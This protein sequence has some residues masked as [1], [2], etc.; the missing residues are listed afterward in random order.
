[1]LFAKQLNLAAFVL[2]PCA[3][4]LFAQTPKP[5]EGRIEVQISIVECTF[6]ADTD[7]LSP[8]WP[9]YEDIERLPPASRMLLD[10]VTA[11]GGP[12]ERIV[13]NH[14][15]NPAPAGKSSL[16]VFAPGE[17]GTKVEITPA[18]SSRIMHADISLQFRKTGG[19]QGDKTTTDIDFSTSFETWNDF[20]V[21]IHVS[22]VPGQPGRFICVIARMRM[23][24][25]GGTPDGNGKPGEGAVSSQK[26]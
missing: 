6:P 19:G 11:A 16:M 2:L 9:G 18:G 20:P 14:V 21:V 15:V 4:G 8:H 23:L 13:K 5:A 26:K 17:S 1:M 24:D 25:P 12:G 3:A 22:S 10:I 7:P